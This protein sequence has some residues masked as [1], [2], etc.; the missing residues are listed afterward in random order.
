MLRSFPPHYPISVRFL[1][2]GT[3]RLKSDSFVI[4]NA[5]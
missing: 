4:D 3:R 5:G 2:E 1:V